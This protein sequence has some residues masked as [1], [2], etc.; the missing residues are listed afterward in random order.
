MK[1]VSL[2]LA[3]L[4]LLGACTLPGPLTPVPVSTTPS[5]IPSPGTSTPT[6]TA[7]A[8]PSETFTPVPPSI[9]PPT[10][11]PTATTVVTNSDTPPSDPTPTLACDHDTALLILSTNAENVKVGDSVQ[12]TVTVNNEGCVALGL[13]Q[14]RLYIASDGSQPI[15]TPA[16]PDPVVHYLG[17]SPGQSD[18]AEF[19]LTAAA[20]GQ[21][22]L[23]AT[24]SYEVHIGYPG[25]AYWGG[26][27]SEP[28]VITVSS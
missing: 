15:F 26:A 13:P 7:A 20:S 11:T 22:K 9:Q 4:F 12:V 24:V 16:A 10:D 5:T 21:A 27:G 25:P 28:L 19:T 14:Y 17:V 6:P 18:F 1:S 3:V 8:V 2:V 23:T